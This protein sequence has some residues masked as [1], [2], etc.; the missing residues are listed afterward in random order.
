M[1]PAARE[2]LS[3]VARRQ[4][5]AFRK[6]RELVLQERA[7]HGRRRAEFANRYRRAAHLKEGDRVLFKDPKL[8]K[9]YAGRAA[10]K[11]GMVGPCLVHR[12]RGNRVDLTRI[13]DG[14]FIPEVHAD[15][16]LALP[17]QVDDYERKLPLSLEANPAPGRPEERPS[18]GQLLEAG[19]DA[20]KA[21]RINRPNRSRRS[22][23]SVRVRVEE[24]GGRPLC[25]LPRRDRPTLSDRAHR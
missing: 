2:P 8:S 21:I 18:P 20:A 4:F 1:E 16:L 5:A 11:R 3:E 23:S 14:L 17:S 7:K 19:P 22:S 10:W 24:P 6:L 12:V 9:E 13:S 25:R 15:N